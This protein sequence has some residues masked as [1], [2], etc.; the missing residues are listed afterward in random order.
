MN[1]R[2]NP[3]FRRFE[4][5]FTD[6][7]G[8]LEAVKAAGFKTDGPPE[9]VWYSYKASPLTKLRENR[10]ASG[11]TITTEAK[12]QYA[13]LAAVE[14]NN[15]KVKAE[16]A[17]HKKVLAKKLKEEKEEGKATPIP[18][19]G[20]IDASDLPPMPPSNQ[21]YNP[22]PCPKLRCFVCDSPVYFYEKQDPPTC[23]WCEIKVLDNSTEVC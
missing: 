19:K 4:A 8:D 9:W 6:F 20:Y 14:A 3:T 22:P 12:E 17:K 16:F 5:E 2:W 1:L 18:E 11:L 10:P 7:Q 21:K 23:L 13:P 15:E